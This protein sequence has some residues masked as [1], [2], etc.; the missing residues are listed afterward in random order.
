MIPYNGTLTNLLIKP[1]S[2]LPSGAVAVFTVRVNGADTA[3][4]LTFNNSD[5]T[6][7]KEDTDA[8]SVN[9][10]DLIAIRMQETGGTDPNSTYFGMSIQLKP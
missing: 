5:G 9:K 7:F 4:E 10:G 2:A 1:I 8:V 6:T 3:L